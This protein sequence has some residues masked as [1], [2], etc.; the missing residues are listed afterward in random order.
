MKV[1]AEG[2]ENKEQVNFLLQHGCDYAQGFFTANRS[3]HNK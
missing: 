2:V 3:E 1:I